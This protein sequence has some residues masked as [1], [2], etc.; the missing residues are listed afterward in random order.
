MTLLEQLTEYEEIKTLLKSA[1]K[2]N[3]SSGSIVGY[4]T[5]GTKITYENASKTNTLIREYN[6]LISHTEM[7]IKQ[8]NMLGITV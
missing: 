4:T 6:Q 8:L 1:L 7:Q 5:N 3:L 2:D